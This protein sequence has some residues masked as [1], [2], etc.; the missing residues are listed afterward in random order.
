M[1]T[2]HQDWASP[3]HAQRYVELRTKLQ[4]D[5]VHYNLDDPADRSIVDVTLCW[6]ETHELFAL[7]ALMKGNTCT[8]RNRSS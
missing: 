8:S 3:R 6:Y 2:D 4:S 7:H 5:G 1:S